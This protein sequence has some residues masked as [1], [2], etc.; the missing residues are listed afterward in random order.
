MDSV[1]DPFAA[2]RALE[3]QR[4][5]LPLETQAIFILICV[6][7]ILSMRPT[8]DPA[9]QEYLRVIWDLFDGDRSR[10]PMVAD[11]LEERV[12]ID[13]RDELAALFHAVRAL[14]GSHE[15][16]AWG[17]H[18]LLDDAYERIPRA[19]DQTSFPPLA[20]ETAHEVVQDELR[21]Q[22]SVLESLS[23]ADL[24]ARIVYLRER[25]R[26]RRGVGH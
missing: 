6:E 14:R 16:A 20:D 4:E 24:A 2:W 5:A 9:G 13:D 1:D 21:W 12:D 23:A 19:V 3:A 7:S 18:R 15:D 25:A 22:R 11:T 10:L 17:A 8:R 26:T